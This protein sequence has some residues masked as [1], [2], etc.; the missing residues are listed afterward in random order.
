MDF[1]QH[2]EDARRRTSALIVYYVLAVILIVLA[3]YAAAIVLAGLNAPE[4]DAAGIAAAAP[5]WW[6]PEVF[7]WIAGLTLAV[8]AAG[9]FY[10]VA[11]LSS[12]GGISV[13]RPG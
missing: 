3:I 12:G 4:T 2:Q 11:S 9:T 7:V 8:V 5:S 1:F 10:K 6:Q 13:A